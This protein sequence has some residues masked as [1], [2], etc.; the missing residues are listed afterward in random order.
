MVMNI[1]VTSGTVA[2]RPYGAVPFVDLFGQLVLA[3]DILSQWSQWKN[4][5]GFFMDQPVHL[6]Q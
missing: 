5:M 3:S 1:S 4:R 6:S 2:P